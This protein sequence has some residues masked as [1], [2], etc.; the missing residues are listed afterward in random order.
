MVS[1]KLP[2][3]KK[4]IAENDKALG[5]A[6]WLTFD[7]AG[8]QCVAA[9][10]C[11]VCRKYEERLNSCRHFNRDFIDGSI[12]IFSASPLKIMPLPTCTRKP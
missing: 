12:A 8:Q 9:L 6:L 11:S 5:T 7:K 1:T 3:S 10:K 4:R 2:P